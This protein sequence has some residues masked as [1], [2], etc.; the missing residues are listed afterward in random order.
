MGCDCFDSND[1]PPGLIHLCNV[2]ENG[3]FSVLVP[4]RKLVTKKRTQTSNLPRPR[5]SD[6]SVPGYSALHFQDGGRQSSTA[7]LTVRT[8][9]AEELTGD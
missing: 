1:S 7:L 5:L 9:R 8:K 2:V 6:R 4:I 3:I